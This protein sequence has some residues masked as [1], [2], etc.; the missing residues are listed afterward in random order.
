MA[1]LKRHYSFPNPTI[2]EALCEIHFSLGAEKEWDQS[3]YGDFYEKIRDQFPKMEPRQIMD[4]GA[5]FG[6]KGMAQI[7]KPPIIRMFYH[8]NERK[9]LL[10][11]SPEIFTIN[12]LK[13]YPGWKVF[14]NDIEKSWKKLCE[15]LKPKNITRIG[16]R[17]INQ[18][19]RDN[20]EAIGS[21]LAET[22]YYPKLILS[23]KTGFLSRFEHFSNKGNKIVITIAEQQSD[24]QDNNPIIFDIDAILKDDIS[25]QWKDFKSK[26]NNLHEQIWEVFSSSITERLK[27]YLEEVER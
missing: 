10:Q 18:I 16:L 26:L 15:V 4:V 11:L 12:E 24:Q 20:N 13:R 14:S 22:E 6:P 2:V 9:H 3:W 27:S 17:Y 21:W 7:V 23:I 25:T 19:P 1:S 8:H 5:I